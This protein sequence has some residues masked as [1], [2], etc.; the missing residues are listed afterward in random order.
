MHIKRRKKRINERK[1]TPISEWSIKNGFNFLFS[2]TKEQTPSEPPRRRSTGAIY[3]RLKDKHFD[4]V[5]GKTN[6][7]ENKQAKFKLHEAGLYGKQELFIR[8][9]NQTHMVRRRSY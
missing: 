9:E 4:Q 3:K 1:G 5:E 7:K 6:Q 2:F 8:R